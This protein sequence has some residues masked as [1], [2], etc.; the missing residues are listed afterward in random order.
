M[1]KT[2][3]REFQFL[4]IAA[5][6][7]L[8]LLLILLFFAGCRRQ[9]SK[10]AGGVEAKD[11]LATFQVADGFKI[12]MI[13]SEP[14]IS[15]PVD[16][17]IDEYGRL[18]V[19]EM[20][21]YP[22][23]KSGSGKI[24]LLSDTDG[25]GNM[26]KRTVFRE[27]LVLPNSIMRWK[28]GVL[29]TDAP[30]LLYL[31]DADGDGYAET[32]DTLL[33]GFALTNPQHN[34]N[35][36]VY[37]ID[38]FI[39]VANEGAVTT[40]EYKEA[41]GDEGSEIVFYGQPH[42]PRLPKNANGRSIRFRPETMQLEMAGGRCQFG[43]TFDKWG[44][45]FACHNSNQ[46]FH[47]VIAS[48][49]FERNPD[50]PV[51]VAVHNMSDHMNAAEV[52]PVTANPDRQIF[53]NVGVMTSACGLT[54]YSGGIFPAPYDGNITFVAEPVSNLVHVDVLEDTG[55]SFTAKRILQRK[56]FLASTDSWSRPV[57]MYVGPDG[58]LYVLDY[59]RRVIESPEW[60]S[61]EAINE[62]DL[63]EGSDKGRIFRI[64]PTDAGKA[65]WTKGLKLGDAGNEELVSYLAHTN[66]W[67][68]IN[69]QRRLVDRADKNAVPFLVRMTED[70]SEMGRLHALWTL[71]GMGALS[72]E[73][74]TRALKDSIAGI[75]ENAVRL[76]ELH[77]QN[78]PRLSRELLAL[79]N[80]PDPKV[81][82]QL[83]LTLGFINSPESVRVRNK[84]LF[85]NVNDRWVQ[86][87]ALSAPPA[88]TA[89][90]LKVVLDKLKGKTPPPASLV[91]RLATM[92]GKGGD[93][94]AI[95]QLIEK[96]LA[97]NQ[98]AIIQGL[99]EGIGSRESPPGI[100]LPVQRKLIA[101]FFENASADMR[102]AAFQLLRVNGITDTALKTS[103][104]QR[105][106]GIMTDTAS[107]FGRRTE[108]IMFITIGDPSV[109][110][111]ELKKLIAPREEL[112]V[113]LAALQALSQVKGTVVS[114]H[115]IQQWPA[116]TT[117]VR[118]EAVK[119]F[120]ADTLRM[121]M[122]IEAMEADKI[123]AAHISFGA[124]VQI[125]LTKN[126]NIRNRARAL[127][128][129]T[130]KEMKRI[131]KEYQQALELKG[132]PLKGQVVYRENCA[133]CHQV[134]GKIGVAI[135]PD[136]GTIHNW[137]R[138]DIMANILDPNLSISSGFDMWEARTANGELAQGIIVSET[139][140]AITFRNNGKLDRTLNRKDIV[141]LSAL[142]LSAMPGGFEKTIS[143]QQMADLLAFLRKP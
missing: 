50:L 30:N 129:K 88:Q 49:Y 53:T 142:N 95:R 93:E 33:H 57:N 135:G 78:T 105:A 44:R 136:L 48:H 132:D 141:S 127:F 71:E 92:I 110:M 36:P 42:T 117:E 124:S 41:F 37:S 9:P 2:S 104:I 69:A 51:S 137:T 87:A 100:S 84:L 59:Y 118:D 26:D 99:A 61:E 43:H 122:L 98:A 80:D 20:H 106:A 3:K 70:P 25:D 60:M 131:N 21:G 6:G 52:F 38:N 12:E 102:K 82:I 116:L 28:K 121:L 112:P 83:L 39:Y 97:D 77:L 139:P 96:A 85:G 94:Q 126:D 45:R 34:V 128:T 89:A 32:L 91:E 90:L 54:S 11:A 113:Q 19:V 27:N 17:E 73:L 75:R 103:S 111:E 115:T 109:Y 79:Q 4:N 67:Q 74:I 108:A 31:E 29:V 8:C 63:Y 58:A 24:I 133:I 107:P 23:D 47:E 81:R 62:G 22:L 10:T 14:L 120:L 18:Y 138:E 35:S 64:T 76:A 72:P 13:A 15:D 55:A 125:M 65:D 1:K 46:G 86:I 5:K 134:R 7:I 66:G 123:K 114:E 119:T 16:M 130:E 40:R 140:T 56:E 68:R 143:H 101:D